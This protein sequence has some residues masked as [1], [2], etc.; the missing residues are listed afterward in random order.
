[1]KRRVMI[2]YADASPSVRAIY[3]EGMR[4]LGRSTVPNWMKAMGRN[5]T[6]LK[7]NWEKFRHVVLEG[8]VPMLL[9]QLILFV[10]SINVGN[11]YCT[12][13]HGH[14]VLELDKT[15]T[16]KDL[17]SLSEGEAYST[18][19]KSFQVAIE[20]V[21]RAALHPKEVSAESFDFENR[22]KKEGF[23]EHEIDE[24]MAQADFGV[25]MNTITDILDIPVDVEFT[26]DGQIPEKRLEPSPL[27]KTLAG[28]LAGNC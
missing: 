26:S 18:L 3:D 16:Y 1:M 2:E 6:V 11:R 10:I 24:L 25:M 8:T 13:A 20:I 5:E 12:A 15:L 28:D 21:T 4:A 7:A 19:P 22:L 17:L 14:A 23:N 27:G 9:K